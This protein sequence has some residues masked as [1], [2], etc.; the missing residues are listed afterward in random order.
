MEDI[1]YQLN[2]SQKEAVIYNDGP[3]LVVAGAG[4]GKTRVLTY[5]IVYLLKSGYQPHSILALTFTNKASREMQQRIASITDDDLVHHLWMGTFHSIFYKILRRESQYIGYQSDFTIYDASDSKNLIKTIIKE[6]GLDE[7][8]YKP[9]NVQNR[10]SNAKNSL[11]TSNIYATNK[12]LI[13][14][15]A[16]SKVPLVKGIYKR[17]QN[18]CY[19]AGVM[20]FDDL[21][22]Y[23]NILFRDN[24]EVLE[25]YR[26]Q[27]KYVLVDEYQDT[28]F[29]QH[30]IV[31]QLSEKH[32]HICVVGDDAQSIYSFRGANI[33]NMLRFKDNFPECKVFKLERNYRSTQNIVDAANSVI[34]KNKGQ[35]FKN[36]YSE[37]EQGN[38][39]SVLS[40]YS[41]YEEGYIVSSKIL[42]MIQLQKCSYSD[43]AIL[44]RTNSQSRIL[45]EAM[46]K[47]MIPYKI[48]GSQSFYQ[49]KEIKDVVAYLRI[50]INPHDEEALK[51]IINYPIRG[52]GDTTME[53][54]Q[55]TAVEVNVSLWTVISD[56]I[57]FEILMN[58]GKLAKLD[59]F[60]DMIIDFQSRNNELSAPELLDYVLKKSGLAATLFM[61][62]SVEGIGRQDNVKELMNAMNEFVTLRKEEGFENFSLTDFLTEISLLTD[63]DEKDEEGKKDVVVM[64]TV[65]AAKGLEFE[66]VMIVGMEN[67]LFPSVMSEGNT[68][69]IEEERRLFYVAITR[70]KQNCIITY[71]KN[72]FRYGKTNM[73]SPS[74][75]L[76]DIDDK[77]VDFPDDMELLTQNKW[78]DNSF[79]Q[80]KPK[81]SGISKSIEN[82]SVPQYEK[83]EHIPLKKETVTTIGNISVGN[84]VQH[85]RFGEGE[86][87]MLEESGN[88]SKA[89][90]EFKNAGTKCLLLKYAKL[91]VLKNG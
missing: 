60:Y 63:Q 89:T 41:D 1:T 69:A 57:N 51:R 13:E 27:F 70:A 16:R 75:F 9:G 58:K 71:A 14:Y 64:M 6:M 45:E 28:N 24:P 68:R 7:N 49:R 77:Y 44:Y 43:F 87:V 18:R 53:K 78:Y 32:R 65:H 86:V 66:N 73:A 39:I 47:R 50:I 25:K 23:T 84:I 91:N 11:I 19:N 83:T 85:D 81:Y 67:G 21:L 15:D 34:K 31:R 42:E 10:I 8:V 61:D 52:I 17:Y 56:R 62:T 90:V 79:S 54:L 12:D 37:K 80:E 74:Y 88:D 46:R 26:N 4:S 3:S 2:S 29:A 48:Y 82:Q 38:K 30:L 59:A 35:I 33:D 36:V 5:K 72:R 20:D 40:A 76:K 55:S 22:L